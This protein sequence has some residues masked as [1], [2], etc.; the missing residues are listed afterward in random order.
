MRQEGERKEGRKGGREG[1]K[2]R[3]IDEQECKIKQIEM[4]RKQHT[5][6]TVTTHTHTARTYLPGSFVSRS[7]TSLSIAAHGSVM[8]MAII[9]QSASPSVGGVG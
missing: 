3:N 6:D 2:G 4:R 1:E 9:F 5:Q 8:A 7:V